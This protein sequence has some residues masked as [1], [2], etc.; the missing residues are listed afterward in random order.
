MQRRTLSVLIA[1]NLAL[2]AAIVATHLM[3]PKVANAQ[4]FG[5]R[6]NFTMI[7]GITTGRPQNSVIYVLD[8]SSGDMLATFYNS[9][10]QQFEPLG[11][12][13]VADDMRSIPTN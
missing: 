4:G 12:R 7:A 2:V 3:P 11:G 5:P 8:A 13:A 1:L 6:R 10:N 9:A